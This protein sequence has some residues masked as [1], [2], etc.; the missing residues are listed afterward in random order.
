MAL[1]ELSYDKAK[2]THP[3]LESIEP[4]DIAKYISVS[5]ELAR[6]E[7]IVYR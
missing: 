7:M 6:F 5:Q 2:S 3:D 4:K 1:S